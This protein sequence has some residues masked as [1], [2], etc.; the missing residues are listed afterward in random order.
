MM[1]GAKKRFAK[2]KNLK[3][4]E[5]VS[6]M[7]GIPALFAFGAFQIYR[8]NAYEA[9]T[10]AAKVKKMEAKFVSKHPDNMVKLQNYKKKVFAIGIVDDISV[11]GSKHHETQE[12]KLNVAKNAALIRDF[13]K[14]VGADNVVL[15]MCDERYEDEIA[16]IIAHPN[17]DFTMSNVHKFLKYK[18]PE[19]ILR[20]D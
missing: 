14:Q 20:H 11:R 9:E 18:K 6:Y 19:K 4:I 5:R 15:E 2:Y 13:I 17:Y 7:V 3:G 12:H 10:R 16:D 1:E 8:K